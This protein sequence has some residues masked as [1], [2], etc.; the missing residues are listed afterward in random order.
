MPLSQPY[1]LREEAATGLH[2]VDNPKLIGL[3]GNPPV[4]LVHFDLEIGG[5]QCSNRSRIGWPGLSGPAFAFPQADDDAPG[6][7]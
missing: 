2:R 1:W 4:L 6:S 7:D 3:P 5:R